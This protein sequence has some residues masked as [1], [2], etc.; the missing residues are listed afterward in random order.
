MVFSYLWVNMGVPRSSQGSGHWA[1]KGCG[2][3]DYAYHSPSLGGHWLCEATGPC[4]YQGWAIQSE[5]PTDT[6]E[7]IWQFLRLLGTADATEC[8]GKAE[9]SV[10][11]HMLA[12]AW[13][14]RERGRKRA[15]GG[16]FGMLSSWL[17]SVETMAENAGMR[18][19]SKLDTQL[20]RGRP[21]PLLHHGWFWWEEKVHG[22]K[23]FIVERQE[24]EKVGSRGQP[25]PG[26][27]GVGK[28]MWWKGEQGSE[29]Q[30]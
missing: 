20:I 14:W 18:T 29:K 17:G 4:L 10:G 30:E 9:N 12:L 19:C 16:I 25:W 23:V 28:G 3:F 13:G 1:R 21:A 15:P 5:V 24:R 27:G 6:L 26:Q 22:F 8:C 2:K 11:A 7:L